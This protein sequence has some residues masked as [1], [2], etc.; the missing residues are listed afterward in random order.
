M[1]TTL[2]N[3]NDTIVPLIATGYDAGTDSRNVLHPVIGATAPSV[4]LAPDTMR[5]STLS[6]LFESRAD[7]WAA[8]T[9]LAVPDV[10]NLTDPDVPEIGMTFVRSGS[11]RI[12]LDPETRTLWL[13][14]VGYQEVGSP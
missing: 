3:G 6:L 5:A 13:L 8:H 4:S 1:T 9:L 10:W 2:T 7:A 12:S 14:D 11:M